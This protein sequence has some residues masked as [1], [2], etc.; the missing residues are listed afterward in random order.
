VKGGPTVA[1][2]ADYGR[3]NQAFD[4]MDQIFSGVTSNYEALVAQINHRM[5]H[6]L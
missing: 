3:P 2:S 4:V 6:N 1:N 5:S